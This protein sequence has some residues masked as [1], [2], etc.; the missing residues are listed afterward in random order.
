MQETSKNQMTMTVRLKFNEGGMCDDCDIK[1]HAL[2]CSAERCCIS[3]LRDDGK[4]GNWIIDDG[5]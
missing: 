2:M 3:E 1:K 5:K 4:D